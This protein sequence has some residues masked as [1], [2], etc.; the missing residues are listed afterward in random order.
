MT[1]TE[2][3]EASAIL[4]VNGPPGQ[5][6]GVTGYDATP[7]SV[8]LTW[9]PGVDN[10]RPI[11]SYVVDAH[12]SL[13]GGWKRIAEN[14]P[15]SQDVNTKVIANITGLNPYTN[16]K[17]RVSG[18][19]SIGEGVPSQESLV[20]RTEP[21]PPVVYPLNLGGGGG[22]VGTLNITWDPLPLAEWNAA[23]GSVGYIVYWMRSDMF[24]KD[25]MDFKNL[26]D[27][28]ADHHVV[29][30]GETNFYK[31]Y[32]VCIRVYNPS[33]P[34]PMSPNI[35][36]MSAEGLPNGVPI[37]VKAVYFNAT[38]ITVEWTP[39]ADTVDVMRGKLL[40]YRIN[41]WIDVQ[42]EE[43]MALFKI[44]RNQ[45][46]IGR[47]IGL[48][49]NTFYMINVQAINTAGNGP[50]SENYRT[51]TL[52]SAPMEAPQDV[53]VSPIDE[54]SVLIKWRGVFTTIEEEPLEGYIVRY[55]ERGQNLRVGTNMDAGKKIEYVLSGL[56]PNVQY[57]LRVF[58]VSRGGD[59]LQSSPT[60]E[61]VLGHGCVVT[62][63]SPDKEYI[64]LCNGFQPLRT[65]S[66]TYFVLLLTLFYLL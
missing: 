60:T 49:P 22:K 48:V 54:Q 16:Y 1:T 14:I 64:Y 45:T 20:Y 30:I 36:I 50:K 4:N 39:V 51:R 2:S 13:Y 40:G 15:P 25:H 12:S 37:G 65:L 21:A 52:R 32:N 26:T 24:E 62:Q 11:T 18:V 57:Q 6:G 44:I 31:P 66:F 63:D 8:M 33:G 28:S 9:W 5:P 10:G 58:G 55:W 19:N 34:G 56:K 43:T 27:M 7:K 53:R 29:T 46:D 47:I 42:E 38:A 23:V 41:Y 61:F 59:G 35:T 17:F 3:I